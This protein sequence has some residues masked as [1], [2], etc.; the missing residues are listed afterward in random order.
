MQMRGP[1]TLSHRSPG[2][3]WDPGDR[4]PAA[5]HAE[6]D[7]SGDH[8]ES[9]PRHKRSHAARKAGGQSPA[10][11][12]PNLFSRREP[13]EKIKEL[14]TSRKF[15][16]AL[17]GLVAVVVKSVRPDF[18]LTDQQMT[19]IVYLLVAFIVGTSIEAGLRGA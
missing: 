10:R 7:S 9:A 3:V 19:D 16:A 1:D 4:R 12:R 15:W 18:P 17:I 13:M 14:L 2:F 5:G 6:R 8:T 11:R